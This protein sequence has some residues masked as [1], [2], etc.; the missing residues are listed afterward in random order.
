MSQ[1]VNNTGGYP[2]GTEYDPNAPW[3]RPDAKEGECEYCREEVECGVGDE[4]Q[5]GRP[6]S[7]RWP[8]LCEMHWPK[9]HCGKPAYPLSENGLCAQCEVDALLSEL[10][11]DLMHDEVTRKKIFTIR[12]WE[13]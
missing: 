10:D 9:C 1:L 11:G 2:S 3:N 5:Q 4:V 12:E 7:N 6:Y 13:K 8:F